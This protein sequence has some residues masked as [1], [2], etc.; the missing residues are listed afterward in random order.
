[1]KSEMGLRKITDT[2]AALDRLAEEIARK[3]Q[4]HGFS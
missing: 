2:F 1:M 4:E 3:H